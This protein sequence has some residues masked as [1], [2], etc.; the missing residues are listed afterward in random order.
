MVFRCVA[1]HTQRTK[2]RSFLPNSLLLRLVRR[3]SYLAIAET[4]LF[5]EQQFGP[6]LI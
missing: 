3:R 5:L 6:C 4:L 2:A 1:G